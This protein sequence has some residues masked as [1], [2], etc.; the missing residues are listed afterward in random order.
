MNVYE[1]NG[2]WI[3]AKSKN[4]AYYQ[5]LEEENN[6]EDVFD[7]GLELHENDDDSY[8]INIR[9]LKSNEITRKDIRCHNYDE[10]DCE[11]CKDNDDYVYE[12]LQD[13]IDRTEQEKFPCVIAKED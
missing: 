10:D 9:R 8:I 6:L 4:E 3:A 11:M 13:V 7:N 12:S 2:Y 5:F 1:I